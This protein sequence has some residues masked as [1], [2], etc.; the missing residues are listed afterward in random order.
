M[1]CLFAYGLLTRRGVNDRVVPWIAVASPL[2]CLAIDKGA[3]S[4]GYR[5][6][7]ELLMLNGA[8]TFAGLY[9]TGNKTEYHDKD[10]CI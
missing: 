1:L 2:I 7:Y 10:H 4:M 8:I 5:F 3:A 9:L 6:G